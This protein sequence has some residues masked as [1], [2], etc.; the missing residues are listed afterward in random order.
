MKSRATTR[1][2]E[3]SNMAKMI[4]QHEEKSSNTKRSVEHEEKEKGKWGLN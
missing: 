2:K 4:A 3:E 1:R